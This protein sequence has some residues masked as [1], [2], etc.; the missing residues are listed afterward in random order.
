MVQFRPLVVVVVALAA[1][2]IALGWIRA[3]R[4]AEFAPVSV[5]DSREAL[6]EL[7]VRVAGRDRAVEPAN[8]YDAIL[9]LSNL[10]RIVVGVDLDYVEKGLSRYDAI[11]RDSEGSRR[12]RG[13]IRENCF[14]DGRFLL[15]LF[16][17]RFPAGDYT[18]DIEGFDSGATEGRIVAS[19]WFQVSRG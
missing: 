5:I 3:R 11:I 2:V 7:P 6:Q 4:V 9:D 18:L 10:D 15:R 16:A 19:S 17:R 14:K 13:Q 8:T 1:I 12:F